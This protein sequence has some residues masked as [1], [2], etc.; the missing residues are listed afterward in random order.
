MISQ[1]MMMPN[2]LPQ[3]EALTEQDFVSS[4]GEQAFKEAVGKIKDY[5]LAGDAMQVVI[6]QQ[7]SVDF[8]A[9]P[10]D[11]YRALRYLN[12][13][14]YMFFV[15]LGHLQIVGSSPEILVRL[16]DNTVT[17]RPIAGTRRRGLTPEKD[18][19]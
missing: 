12:P 14:P 8:D 6:S 11:L 7:M 15:D 19:A 13:S 5:I 18:H 2:D 3:A 9:A 17:V 1:P 4:F 10:I 16:E